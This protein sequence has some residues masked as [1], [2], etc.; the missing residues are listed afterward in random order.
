MKNLGLLLI[1]IFTLSA[2][3]QITVFND[4]FESN[5]NKWVKT[6]TWGLTTVRK[7]AGNRS[8]TDSPGGNY[9]NNTNTSITMNNGV[10]LDS[11][12]DAELSFWAVYDIETGFDYCYVDVSSDNWSSYTRIATF[13]GE[14]NLTPWTQY[15]YSLGGF[16]GK[17]N[18]KVRF[19]F[20]TD[21]GYVVDGIYI[22]DLK[23]TKDTVDKSPPLIIHSA[24]EHYESTLGVQYLTADIIDT[25]GVGLAELNLYSRWR[26]TKYDNGCQCVWKSV[27]FQYSCT[28]GRFL[29]RLLYYC[30]R[31]SPN[32]KS[33]CD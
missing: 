27:Y 28:G 4:N 1:T 23:I 25:S 18:V 14:N 17:T 15:T 19:L 20:Y 13:N 24:P 29:G 31:Y 30:R 11:C 10:A 16:I 21:A 22:D 33:S 5:N 7:H 32:S 3:A 8:M 6:G 2:S 9:L 26:S 12:L